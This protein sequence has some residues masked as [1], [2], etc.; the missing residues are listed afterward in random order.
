[1]L[2]RWRGLFCV[3]PFACEKV[4]LFSWCLPAF[5]LARYGIDY[6]ALLVSILKSVFAPA[7]FLWLHPSHDGMKA[8]KSWINGFGVFFFFC[9]QKRC[10][11]QLTWTG[12]FRSH[13]AC[14]TINQEVLKNLGN[15]PFFPHCIRSLDFFFFD[16]PWGF[17]SFGDRVS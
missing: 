17:I 10:V 4:V 15:S 7:A 12:A 6:G 2:S 3:G 13:W 8:S 5:L 16:V 11:Q 14:P 9:L 1:M